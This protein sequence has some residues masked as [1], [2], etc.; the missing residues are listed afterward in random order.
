MAKENSSI[1]KKIVGPPPATMPTKN[2]I[3]P[4]EQNMSPSNENKYSEKEKD[5]MNGT[6]VERDEHRR[7]N[8]RISGTTGEKTDY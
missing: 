5:L 4:R 2:P 6:G 1:P 7:P 3:T 8:V